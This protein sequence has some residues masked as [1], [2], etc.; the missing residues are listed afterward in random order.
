MTIEGEKDKLI[1]NQI[2]TILKKFNNKED[3][4]LLLLSVLNDK[5]SKEES[6]EETSNNI[7][8]CLDEEESNENNDTNSND[9]DIRIREKYI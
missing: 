5:F 4:A 2:Q 8:I 9:N 3:I 7:T 6:K 1:F